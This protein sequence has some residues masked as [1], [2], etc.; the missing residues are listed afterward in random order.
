MYKERIRI[1]LHKLIIE[2]SG[3]TSQTGWSRGRSLL[4]LV[5]INFEGETEKTMFMLDAILSTK[6]RDEH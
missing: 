4:V 1:N 6:L 5:E 3:D 2:A